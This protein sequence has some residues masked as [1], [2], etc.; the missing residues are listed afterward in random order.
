MKSGFYF[1]IAFLLLLAMSATAAIP[2]QINYQGRLTDTNGDPLAG[3]VNLV[4][5]ICADSL[6]STQLWSE[7]HNGV[8]LNE[9]L[10][11]VILGTLTPIPAAVFD[12][13]QRY[14]S[15]SLNGQPV[16]K[17]IAIGSVGYAYHSIVSDTAVALRGGET[18]DC[19]DCNATFVNVAGPD[20]V[21]VSLGTAFLGKASGARTSDLYGLKGYANNTSSGDTYGGRFETGSGGTGVHYALSAAAAGSSSSGVYGLNCTSSNSSTGA[22]YAASLTAEAGGTGA[23]YGANIHSHGAGASGMYGVWSEGDNTS[24]GTAY[25]GYFRTSTS[26]T[27]KHWGVSGNANSASDAEAYATYGYAVNS[28]TGDAYGGYFI[29][30]SSGTGIHYGVKTQGTSVSSSPVHGIQS[31]GENSGTGSTYGGSFFA[32]E[33]GTGHHYGIYSEASGNSSNE[34]FA[35]YATASNSGSAPAFGGFFAANGLDG[36]GRTEALS[37]SA[38]NDGSHDAIGVHGWAQNNAADQAPYRYTLG[39][40]FEAA[41]VGAGNKH[42]IMAEGPSEGYS[43]AGM[44]FGGVWVN[45][46][47]YVAGSKSAVVKAEDENYRVVYCQESPEYWFEDFGNGK[48][49][50]GRANVE[51]DSRFLATVT[52]D[53][54]HEMKV[55]V[56]LEDECNGVY[57][58][59][60]TKG[61]NVVE[62]A[63]G[64]SNAAFSYRVVAK[65]KGYED[66]RLDLLKGPTPE[67]MVAMK[68]KLKA[69]LA[70]SRAK[71]EAEQQRNQLEHKT[72]SQKAIDPAVE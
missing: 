2:Q 35:V 65:R 43:G 15:A 1:V 67:Q 17:R 32:H 31:I 26:G 58:E 72:E 52:V 3:P 16:T 34:S 19:A 9:G 29:T 7:T 70:A 41:N 18:T 40:Y 61:F 64:K 14:L 68:D 24:T 71:I 28:S 39:G 23:H 57:V 66:K 6:C 13:S 53:E 30:S 4:F 55:F 42:A 47:F 25:G 8:V 27:G 10:F 22:V 11:S 37:G 36:T 69:E 45:N 50:N 60:G 48:L 56:Q 20:S 5:S 54:K 59:K 46:D 38:T 63:N 12:G 51:L 33:D 21:Y 44:F 62:L 49:L